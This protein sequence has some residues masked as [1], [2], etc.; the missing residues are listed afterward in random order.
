MIAI[1]GKD[2]GRSP[3]ANGSALTGRIVAWSVVLMEFP[4]ENLMTPWAL[5]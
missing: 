5:K 2:A 3:D 1:D 4:P